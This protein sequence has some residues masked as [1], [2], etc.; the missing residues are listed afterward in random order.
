M[1]DFDFLDHGLFTA[2]KMINGLIKQA[3]A[4][5]R[6][7]FRDQIGHQL[8]EPHTIFISILPG[9]I[10]E[11]KSIPFLRRYSGGNKAMFNGRGLHIDQF[12]AL[13][14]KQKKVIERL[15]SMLCTQ[16]LGGFQLIDHRVINQEIDIIDVIR[17]KV[18]C[19]NAQL[20]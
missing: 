11:H 8:F 6:A 9:R 7:P 10:I 5:K 20:H 18:N 4:K 2:A 3:E 14:A 17:N 19:M 1:L 13:H 12:A 16:S 15:P